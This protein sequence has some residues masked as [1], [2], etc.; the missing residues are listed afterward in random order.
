MAMQLQCAQADEQ[1]LLRQPKGSHASG[2]RGHKPTSA[3]ATA[4]TN[5]KIFHRH[6]HARTFSRIVNKTKGMKLPKNS[7]S[8]PYLGYLR[9]APNTTRA[10]KDT[11]FRSTIDP[12]VILHSSASPYVGF[13]RHAP[14]SSSRKK[15]YKYFYS[16]SSNSSAATK[17]KST[18]TKNKWSKGTTRDAWEDYLVRYKCSGHLPGGDGNNAKVKVTRRRHTNHM[19]FTSYSFCRWLEVSPTSG[20]FQ[21]EAEEFGVHVKDNSSIVNPLDSLDM[22]NK[23]AY[24]FIFPVAND[25]TYSFKDHANATDVDYLQ[26]V[27]SVVAPFFSSLLRKVLQFD[28]SHSVGTTFETAEP[29]GMTQC[30]ASSHSLQDSLS[31]VHAGSTSSVDL[32]LQTERTLQ[33]IDDEDLIANSQENNLFRSISTIDSDADEFRSQSHNQHQRHLDIESILK[34]PTM[35]FGGDNSSDG[36]DSS[37]DVNE[38]DVSSDTKS[39]KYRREGTSTS[40]STNNKGL[41]WSWIAVPKDLSSSTESLI[42]LPESQRAQC[43]QDRC[44]IC[45]ETFQRGDRLRLLPCGH[46]FHCSCIDKWLS[47]SFSHDNCLNSSCPTCKSIPTVDDD[48][49]QLQSIESMVSIGSVGELCADD[50]SMQ[51]LNLDGSVPAWAFARLGSKIAD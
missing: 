50:D 48:S 7:N 13:I 14:P 2:T 51:S 33:E 12:H 21:T 29:Q 24:W 26:Q 35:T 25:A 22:L 39:S 4:S 30:H 47:G 16:S 36:M 38:C 45:L 11:L 19:E 1:A 18:N 8:S 9:H 6:R 43:K 40:R 44:V 28:F 10:R 27:A 37:I 23:L 46:R 20:L 5:R 31:S 15:N 32:P 17:H 3:A 42:S 34:M 49:G 41:E